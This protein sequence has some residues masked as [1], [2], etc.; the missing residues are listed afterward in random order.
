MSILRIPV[1]RGGLKES[2]FGV[3]SSFG[4]KYVSGG[5]PV[6]GNW[7]HLSSTHHTVVDGNYVPFGRTEWDIAQLVVFVHQAVSLGFP[8]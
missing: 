7:Q 5:K 1:L 2:Y 4:I 3:C 8:F 6:V